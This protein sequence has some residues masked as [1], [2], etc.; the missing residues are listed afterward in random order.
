MS[1]VCWRDRRWLGVDDKVH[2]GFNYGHD[3]RADKLS[4][5]RVAVVRSRSGKACARDAAAEH[6]IERSA[7]VYSLRKTAMWV[8]REAV[9]A[10]TGLGA[11]KVSP[12]R[13]KSQG[14]SPLY[15]CETIK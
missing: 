4:V 14:S 6:G 12:P 2:S 5:L 11:R 15:L 9:H 8:E 7:Q 1:N 3:Y 13:L 10:S